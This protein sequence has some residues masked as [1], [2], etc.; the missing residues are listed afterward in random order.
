MTAAIITVAN[1]KGGVGKTTLS[2]NL[3]GEL[4]RRDYRVLVV[5]ADPQSTATRWA[6]A[7]PDN[8]IFPA[9]VVGMQGTNS[10]LHREVMKFVNDFDVVVIDC[11][12]ALDSPIPASAFLISDLVLIPVIPSP[13]DINASMGILTLF[14]N[15]LYRNESL[16]GRLVPS[17]CQPRTNI[18]ALCRDILGDLKIPVAAAQL[19]YRTAYKEAMALGG[20]VR[21][22][23]R[24]RG[25]AMAE[26]HK[27]ADEV[28]G[29][30]GNTLPPPAALAAAS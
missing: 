16:Q 26:I 1:Q 17:I 10:K 14:E 13:P 27:L 20:T 2:M 3:A 6:A 28:I 24:N 12:P 25:T 19:T 29:L 8:R 21:D 9:H 22:T 30:L 18:N 5:D 4:G 23:G 7:A 15:A 11:P